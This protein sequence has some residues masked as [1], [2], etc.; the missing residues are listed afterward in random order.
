MNV[1]QLRQKIDSQL[2]TLSPKWLLIISNFIDS[3]QALTIRDDQSAANQNVIKRSKK[4][5][6]ILK[7]TNTWQGDDLEEC[8]HF[9]QKNRSESQF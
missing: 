4:A 8:L 9:V 2:N 7:H 6:D 5:K 1:T 3:I